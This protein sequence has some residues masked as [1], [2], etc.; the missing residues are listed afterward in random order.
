VSAHPYHPGCGCW[1]C[2]RTEDA[3]ERTQKHTPSNRMPRSRGF[4][5]LAELARTRRNSRSIAYQR[6]REEAMRPTLRQLRMVEAAIRCD[7]ASRDAV[8]AWRRAAA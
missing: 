6:A 2:C 3:A 5:W 7:L 1:L 4:E 8:Q